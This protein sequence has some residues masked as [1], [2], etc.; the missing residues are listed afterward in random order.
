MFFVFIFKKLLW[1]FVNNGQPL[2]GLHNTKSLRTSGVV[3]SAAA[4]KCDGYRLEFLLT[5]YLDKDSVLCGGPVCECTE[6]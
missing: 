5:R 6:Q 3:D 1:G 4:F 2:H